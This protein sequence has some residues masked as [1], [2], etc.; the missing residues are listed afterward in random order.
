M[1]S[2]R[3]WIADGVEA[4]LYVAHYNERQKKKKKTPQ[5]STVF[6]KYNGISLWDYITIKRVERAIE[7]I[8]TTEMTRL[9]I[10]AECGFQ[11]PANFYK[12]FRRITGRSP[13]SFADAEI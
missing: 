11:S 4:K 13:Q 2:Y 7:L 10:A 1:T 3:W 12:A 9:Q 6:K 5:L 8:R